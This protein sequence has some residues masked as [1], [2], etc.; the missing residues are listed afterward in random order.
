M[1]THSAALVAGKLHT[2]NSRVATAYT[3]G[4][5]KEKVSK[6]TKFDLIQG[7]YITERFTYQCPVLSELFSFSVCPCDGGVD[8]CM[9]GDSVETMLFGN[10]S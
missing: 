2:I 1:S 5:V 4:L 6:F 10:F 9:E 8:D 3:A 7:T